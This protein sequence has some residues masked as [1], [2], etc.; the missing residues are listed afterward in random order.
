MFS[1]GMLPSTETKIMLSYDMNHLLSMHS[2]QIQDSSTFRARSEKRTS[3]EWTPCSWKWTCAH[4]FCLSWSQIPKLNICDE[5]SIKDKKSLN[6]ETI[7]QLC[8]FFDTPCICSLAQLVLG[9]ACGGRGWEADG[10]GK[11]GHYGASSER[12]GRGSGELLRVWNPFFTEYLLT[13]LIV[14]GSSER[15]QREAKERAGKAETT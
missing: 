11:R 12:A 4:N 15:N 7:L 9:V 2:N 1:L 3:C 5:I 14:G 13:R 8:N 6:L 10:G